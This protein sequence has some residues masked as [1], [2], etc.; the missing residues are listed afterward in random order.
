MHPAFGVEVLDLDLSS[1]RLPSV[2][3]ALR[4]LFERHSAVLLRAQELTPE[5][6]L[7]LARLFGP[8]ESRMG[9]EEPFRIP[10]VSNRAPD[11]SLT[12]PDDLHTLH[13]KAN[14]LWHTD[15]TFLPVPALANLLVSRVV[16]THGG[17]TDLASTRAAFAAMTPE[18]QNRLRRARF[19]H[20]YAHS[21]A[22]IAPEL[23]QLPMF[24]KWPPQTWRAV[25]PNP[26]TGAEAVHVASHA[27]DVEGLDVEDPQEFVE[28]TVA[29]CTQPDFVY[30]HS[31]RPGD[32]LIFD[33]RATLHRGH[34]WPY[35]QERS[36]SSIC[37]SA[38]RASGL[39]AVRPPEPPDRDS[40]ER[41]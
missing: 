9:D 24:R 39:D 1:V 16:P 27:F 17:E 30:S 19:V 14:Q 7:E 21:R 6:H 15:S 23:A 37:V 20:S 11:G 33:E 38:K 10:Q 12:G 31:W 36:L 26:V 5:R 34:A 29:A 28:E 2:Y 25:W 18:A 8:L 4:D 41:R 22:K 13:L 3:P 35:E 32:V 40:G